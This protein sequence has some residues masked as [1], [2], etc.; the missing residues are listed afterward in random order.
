MSLPPH[1]HLLTDLFAAACGALSGWAFYRSG[2]KQSC[3]TASAQRHLDYWTVL[4]VSAL[5]G[6]FWFG[7]TNLYLT[8]V[9]GIGRSA[10][11]A[12]F[13]GIVGV[14]LWKAIK[15]RGGSTGVVYVVPL[16]VGMILGR[17]GCQFSGLDDLTYGAP[18]ALPWGW[19]FGDGIARH[20]SPLYESL[21]MLAFLA[22]FL[23]WFRRAPQVVARIGFYVFIV[24]YAAQRFLIEF[25]KPYGEVIGGLDL[26][27]IGAL[28]LFGYAVF[29]LSRSR[30]AHAARA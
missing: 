4:A 1:L 8:G 22:G 21:A 16:S 6:A 20:P 25:T 9:A 11:G 2:I 12:I 5:I 17:V 3:Y 23:W 27:Q 7:T 10:F 13:G 15:G 19:D 24:W 26:F 14:E 18:T 30:G 29:M 28:L